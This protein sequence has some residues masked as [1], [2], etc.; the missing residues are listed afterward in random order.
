MSH[1]PGRGF[2][3]VLDKE[4]CPSTQACEEKWDHVNPRFAEQKTLWMH[5]GLQYVGGFSISC[6][7]QGYFTYMHAL[8]ICAQSAGCCQF[9]CCA[10][11]LLEL[12][13]S[14]HPRVSPDFFFW[15]F[16]NPQYKRDYSAT[17]EVSGIAMSSNACNF[18]SLINHCN[19]GKWVQV[20]TF[21]FRPSSFFPSSLSSF[22]SFCFAH[23]SSYHSWLSLC[24]LSIFFCIATFSSCSF[25]P[26]VFTS[27]T[28]PRHSCSRHWSLEILRKNVVSF[29]AVAFLTNAV[30]AFT[31]VFNLCLPFE[32]R[33]DWDLVS[34]AEVL[35]P[36]SLLSS[37][38]TELEGGVISVS[39]GM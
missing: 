20:C 17:I 14:E 32:A 25:W 33:E 9:T 15:S 3:S 7:L 10:D 5:V 27:A 1:L 22:F 2:H 18:W 12:A 13:A 37:C 34:F 21:F 16:L 35:L 29:P 19:N 38:L 6:R 24:C 8:R 28:K 30:T 39:K 31:D 26:R 23:H 11:S 36:K 4:H